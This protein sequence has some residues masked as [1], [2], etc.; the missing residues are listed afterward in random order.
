MYQKT[1]LETL[2]IPIRISFQSEDNNPGLFDGRLN[3]ALLL[4]PFLLLGAASREEGQTNRLLLAFALLYI[5]TVY[6]ATDMRV[7]YVSPAIPPLV[8]LATLSL[9]TRR[10]FSQ[11]DRPGLGA[12]ARPRKTGHHHRYLSHLSPRSTSWPVGRCVQWG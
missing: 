11:R 5:L 6:L 7:R 1:P 2:A 10:R 9:N 4:F 8:I 3:F 12:L